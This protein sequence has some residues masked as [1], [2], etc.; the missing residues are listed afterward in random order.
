MSTEPC[1]DLSTEQLVTLRA[2][3]QQGMAVVSE[4]CPS[5]ETLAAVAV[6]ELTSE[7]R[8]L[9]ADHI[10]G[11]VSCA[12]GY[13]TLR[14]LHAAAAQQAVDVPA[15]DRLSGRT[16]GRS[17]LAVA[18]TLLLAIVG[19][20]SIVPAP[21]PPGADLMRGVES[22]MVEPQTVAVSPLDGA[23]LAE[24][25]PALAWQALV[26]ATGYQ[27]RLFDAEA[28]PLWES[29]A[30][31]EPRIDLP[32]A[33]VDQLEMGQAYFW[34]VRPSGPVERRELGPFWFEVGE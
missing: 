4:A 20:R 33:V 21:S 27:V 25:P 31:I 7:E 34:V 6:G 5:D 22:Q 32:S 18:A 30:V 15:R 26:A 13:R 3:Y 12:A 23:K 17:L 28:E 8:T 19:F 24:A 9:V 1:S 14:E 2:T 29:S 16:V 11:C 10:V